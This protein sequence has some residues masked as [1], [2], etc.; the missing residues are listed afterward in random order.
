M[1]K[2]RGAILE[3]KE[4]GQEFRVSPSR[5]LTA[6]YCSTECADAH[7]NDGRKMEK[8]KKV[9]PYCGKTFKIY[10]CHADRRKYCSYEC[11]DKAASLSAPIDRHFYNRTFWRKLRKF[12]L[13]RDGYICQKCQADNVVLHVHHKKRRF[14][15]GTDT[16]D[17]LITL[18]NS[19]HKLEECAATN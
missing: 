5:I 9:C 7:R 18:C 1:A 19:C 13:E 17:N 3:C 10:Q 16:E 14:F 2:F 15:G 6:N 11:K 8:L 12:V 4:C